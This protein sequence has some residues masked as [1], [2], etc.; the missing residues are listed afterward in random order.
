MAKHRAGAHSFE[1][2]DDAAAL[3]P[4]H[5]CSTGEAIVAFVLM[6]NRPRTDSTE[7]RGSMAF[8]ASLLLVSLLHLPA[9]AAP[10]RYLEGQQGV[11]H[12][13][14]TVHNHWRLGLA[15]ASRRSLSSARLQ[16]HDRAGDDYL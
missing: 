2:T 3:A 4:L 9:P 6:G 13:P 8:V 7:T 11:A 15:I 10:G 16:R 12:T 1:E 14:L 5:H